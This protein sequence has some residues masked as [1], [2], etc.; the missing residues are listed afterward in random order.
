MKVIIGADHAGFKLKEK[1]KKFLEKKNILVE[2]VGTFSEDSVDYTGYAFNVA[3][4]IS[5]DKTLKG[6]LICGTGTGMVMAA[7]RV[8]GVRASLIYDKYSAV[9]AREHNDANIICLRGRKASSRKQIKL[10]WLWLN[11]KFSGEVR[12]K[13]RIVKLK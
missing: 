3:R 5:K 10:T 13:R 4:K 8:K 11:T 2:D 7:N 1:L 6:I 9:M 12:H